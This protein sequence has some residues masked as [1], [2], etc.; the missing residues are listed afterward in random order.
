MEEPQKKPKRKR[1]GAYS[2]NKGNAYERLVVNELKQLTGNDNIAT[3]RSASKKL[4]NMKIDIYDEDGILPCYFQLKK[5]K[6]LPQVKK[7]NKE[8][9]KVDKPLCIL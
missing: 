1:S 5:T 6:I 9:G 4:D 8:V 2:K 7:I 3:S